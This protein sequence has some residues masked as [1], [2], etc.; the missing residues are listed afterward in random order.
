MS[1]FKA[2]VR[3]TTPYTTVSCGQVFSYII[4]TY[5]QERT[6]KLRT[7]PPD[8]RGEIKKTTFDF[9][10]PGGL[11]TKRTLTGLIRPSGL[12]V[13]DVDHVS[14]PLSLLERSCYI[15]QPEVAF[16]SPSGDGVKMFLD[17]RGD[18]EERGVFIGDEAISEDSHKKEIAEVYKSIYQDYEKFWNEQFPE[19]PLDKSGSDITRACFL[20][21]NP[22]AYIDPTLFRSYLHNGCR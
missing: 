13:L 12:L 2:P 8:H 16:I 22:T 5:A 10:T 3:N 7:A 19:A 20:P 11:F 6:S 14:D 15:L 17:V 1:F 4:S 21:H 18:Y 9:V